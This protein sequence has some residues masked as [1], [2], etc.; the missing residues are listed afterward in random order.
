MIS[1]LRFAKAL[2][3]V[4][5]QILHELYE[6]VD[7]DPV[8]GKAELLR[9]RDHWSGLEARERAVDARMDAAAPKKREEGS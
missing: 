9:I 7:G 5:N 2:L 4:V 1:F 3:P 6:R 8:R